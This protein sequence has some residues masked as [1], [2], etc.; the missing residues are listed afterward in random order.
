MI[1]ATDCSGLKHWKNH[2]SSVLPWLITRMSVLQALSLQKFWSTF[3][4]WIHRKP[5]NS[6]HKGPVMRRNFPYPAVIMKIFV[7]LF[8][9]NIWQYIYAVAE[10]PVMAMT[11]TAAEPE[12]MLTMFIPIAYQWK[13]LTHRIAVWLPDIKNCV[14]SRNIRQDVLEMCGSL[15]WGVSFTHMP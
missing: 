6:P 2:Q 5:V 7:W 10:P 13:A 9:V 12:G 3:S 11:T 15:T 14:R 8:F 1:Y 4:G